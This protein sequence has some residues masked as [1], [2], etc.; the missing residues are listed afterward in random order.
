MEPKSWGIWIQYVEIV[1]HLVPLTGNGS[2]SGKRHTSHE[3]RVS[4]YFPFQALSSR[5][6]RLPIGC[7]LK[8]GKAYRIP[9]TSA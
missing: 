1:G 2:M 9:L 4:F 6:P 7:E 8:E 5:A 3:D